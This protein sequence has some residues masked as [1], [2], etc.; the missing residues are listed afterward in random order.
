[1]FQ[2][3]VKIKQK[4]RCLKQVTISDEREVNRTKKVMDGIEK[5]CRDMDLSQPFW[6]ESNIKE[7]RTRSKTRFTA[8][9]FI[10]G[11]E[12][13]CMEIQVLEEDW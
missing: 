13:D 4:G 2:L 6:L 11:I 8:D 7:F 10:E 1:M 3:W 12:F 5:A 9:N